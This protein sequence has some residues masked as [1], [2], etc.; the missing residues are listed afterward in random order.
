MSVSP[1]SKVQAF[2]CIETI[3]HAEYAAMCAWRDALRRDFQREEFDKLLSMPQ[4]QQIITYDS[5]EY[6]YQQMADEAIDA[7]LRSAP[8]MIVMGMDPAV[9]SR[10]ITEKHYGNN[11][12]PQ[13]T[14]VEDVIVRSDGGMMTTR[15][16]TYTTEFSDSAGEI[17]GKYEQRPHHQHLLASTPRSPKG[18]H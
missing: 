7:Y 11:R 16:I 4:P 17:R 9:T 5:C 2:V 10:W 6:L 12:R 8:I 15:R 14:I 13:S 3:S 1:Q 18:G